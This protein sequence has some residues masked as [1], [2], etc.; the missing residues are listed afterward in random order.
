MSEL[1]GTLKG[2]RGEATRCGHSHLVTTAATWAG[3]IRVELSR[4]PGE[5][6]G[7]DYVVRFIPWHGR[8]ESKLIAEGRIGEPPGPVDLLARFESHREAM[9]ATAPQSYE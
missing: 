5:P 7:A 2:S 6:A 9:A 1:Y 8:G 4:N 3:A